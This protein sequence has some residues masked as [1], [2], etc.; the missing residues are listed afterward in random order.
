MPQANPIDRLVQALRAEPRIGET[1]SLCLQQLVGSA[2]LAQLGQ[3]GC[4][5]RFSLTWPVKLPSQ[6]SLTDYSRS[7][8]LG[9][10]LNQLNFFGGSL[11]MHLQV[12]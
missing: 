9:V 4:L 7:G 5:I 1:L 12:A 10:H 3:L 8:Y 2:R 11:G 6:V